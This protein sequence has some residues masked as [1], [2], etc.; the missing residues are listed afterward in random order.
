[1][2]KTITVLGTVVNFEQFEK[3]TRGRCLS[4]AYENGQYEMYHRIGKYKTIYSLHEADG[5]LIKK[6]TITNK[7]FTKII[8]TKFFII[9]LNEESKEE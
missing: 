3:L 5:T 7:N 9:K 1:M 4:I 8:L 2:K 6:N